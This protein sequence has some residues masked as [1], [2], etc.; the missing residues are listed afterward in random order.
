MD[1]PSTERTPQGIAA[2]L[3]H[4]EWGKWLVESVSYFQRTADKLMQLFKE[5][6]DKLFA[7]S[8]DDG[9]SNSPAGNS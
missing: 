1:E 8:A 9:R 7:T 4:G 2:L 5:Y 6:G 3:P